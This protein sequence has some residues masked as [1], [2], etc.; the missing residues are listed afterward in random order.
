MVVQTQGGTWR[1]AEAIDGFEAKHPGDTLENE[2]EA[3][4]KASCKHPDQH[5]GTQSS[6]DLGSV[7]S[8][9]ESRG[10]LE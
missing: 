9:R 1:I 3:Q 8:E 10:R 6:H 4:I 2:C 7:E 5:D